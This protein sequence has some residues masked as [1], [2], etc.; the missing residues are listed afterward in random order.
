MRAMSNGATVG[1]LV[2]SA[3]PSYQ[4]PLHIWH[5][6]QPAVLGNAIEAKHEPGANHELRANNKLWTI[7][8]EEHVPAKSKQKTYTDHSQE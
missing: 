5:R 2:I 1:Y 4:V 8:T 6:S 7:N 3:C